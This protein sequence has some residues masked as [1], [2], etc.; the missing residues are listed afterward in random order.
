MKKILLILAVMVVSVI[1]TKAEEPDLKQMAGQMIMVG[2]RGTH[3]DNESVSL[4]KAQ[5]R[6]G[7]VGGVV[8][9]AYNID[10][11][12]QTRRLN[13]NLK[14][15]APDMHPLFTAVD[16]EGGK[17]QRLRDKKGFEDF[18]S[19]QSVSEGMNAVQ[20]EKLYS[21]LARMVKDAGF[22]VNFA[23]VVDLNVNPDSPAIG[24]IG[25][26]FGRDSDT[27]TEYAE[28]F[29]KAH[30]EMGVITSIK[31][32]PGHGSA[33]TDSHK[34]FTDVTDTWSKDELQ[35]YKALL[36]AGM[37]DSIMS[38]HV[39]N[40]KIDTEY[41]ATMSNKQ[42]GMLRKGIGYDGVLFTD[43]LQMGAVSD[44]YGLE[45]AV[46]RSVSAGADVLIY[47]NYFEYVP[48]FPEKAVGYILKG[49]ESGEL[50]R[51]RIEEAYRRIM[52]LKRPL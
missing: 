51:G 48:D 15:S 30:R 1:P 26:S 4:L 20:A 31:H 29:I 49:V 28:S 16:E 14:S 46:V 39:F 40:K 18:P 6:E 52:Q 33:M 5:I 23:P 25:R 50:S 13:D 8:F 27:V 38:A 42:I 47:S 11:P 37:V 12:E 41:P 3:A 2:F 21:K 17:V 34:G 43:D 7:L 10:N 36:D 32:F 22:N 19:H 35:P 24:R 9:Y 45:T 44:N